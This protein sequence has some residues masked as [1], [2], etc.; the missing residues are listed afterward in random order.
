MEGCAG[1][2]EATGIKILFSEMDPSCA[3]TNPPTPLGM[4]N[5]IWRDA[6][7]IGT[8]TDLLNQGLAPLL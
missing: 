8:A 4:N 5:V 7:A 2:L 6:R 3:D 1:G